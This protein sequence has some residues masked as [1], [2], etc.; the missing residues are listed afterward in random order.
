M[1]VWSLFLAVFV[2]LQVSDPYNKT[3]FTLVLE[4]VDFGLLMMLSHLVRL[5][6]PNPS[7]ML[8]PP[9]APTRLRSY[10]FIW[11]RTAVHLRQ[12]QQ[13]FTPFLSNGGAEGGKMHKIALCTFNIFK[14]LN[15]SFCL[16]SFSA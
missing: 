7:L 13:L 5:P 6:G 1:K 8:P 4:D 10:Y 9:S 3:G 14:F 2:S 11:V 12:S 16:Q 15:R